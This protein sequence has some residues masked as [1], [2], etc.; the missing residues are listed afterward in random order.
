MPSERGIHSAA[1][2]KT[3]V[4]SGILT[5]CL[6]PDGGHDSVIGFSRGRHGN[7]PDAHGALGH[8]CGIIFALLSHGYGSYPTGRSFIRRAG[9][10]P[11]DSGDVLRA[12]ILVARIPKEVI[13]RGDDALDL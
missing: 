7:R 10:L 9:S 1:G 8:R 2:W 5:R 11:I 6:A 4:G 12:A 3:Q 13:R